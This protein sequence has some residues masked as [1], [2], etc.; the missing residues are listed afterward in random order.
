MKRAIHSQKE[1]S[2]KQHTIAEEG[3][4]KDHR[5]GEK[6]REEGEYSPLIAAYY[7]IQEIGVEAGGIGLCKH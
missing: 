6:Q 1:L 5:S 3:H 7:S 2:S 4:A